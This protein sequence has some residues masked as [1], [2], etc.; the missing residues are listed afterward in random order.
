MT[1]LIILFIFILGVFVGYPLLNEDTGSVCSALE[2]RLISTASHDQMRPQ[3]EQERVK[4]AMVSGLQAL[5]NGAFASSVI[6]EKYPNL[7]PSLGCA[8]TYW[9]LIIDP[10]VDWRARPHWAR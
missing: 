3:D 8:F 7:P 10:S 2:R 4:M 1:K 5:S 9:R 6:K